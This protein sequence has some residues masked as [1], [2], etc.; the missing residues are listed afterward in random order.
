MGGAFGHRGRV[1]GLIAAVCA[2]AGV[3]ASPGTLGSA[4]LTPGDLGDVLTHVGER[5]EDYYRRAQSIVCVETVR[6]QAVG[7]D[8]MPDGLAHVRQNEVRVSWEP[9]PDDDTPATVTIL[10]QLLTVSGRPPR[11]DAE[12]PCGD[13]S[14]GPDALALIV[15][16]GNR[17]S[18][19][20]SLKG[21]RRAGGRPTV[22]VDF[23]SRTLGKSEVTWRG[24][25]A[26]FTFPGTTGR[27][28]VDAVTHDVVRFDYS[29]MGS[30]NYDIPRDI[31]M[32]GMPTARE[33]RR[34]D[35]ST[36]YRRVAFHDPDEE[37]LLPDTIESLEV[38]NGSG[39]AGARTVRTFSNYRR[40]VTAAR[41]VDE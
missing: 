9:S 12:P 37:L 15:F 18:Y 7:S 11:P 10:R 22:L 35:S 19:L 31:K 16:R 27:I 13:S 30:I 25:C 3:A 8:L 5:V 32:F 40:F 36:R 14:V 23:K 39:A 2:A 28:W 4:K 33:V 26:S 6:V 21:E 20:F 17:D 24:K 1:G 29:L 41:V 34:W 38:I